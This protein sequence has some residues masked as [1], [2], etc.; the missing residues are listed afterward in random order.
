METGV[1]PVQS[2][3]HRYVALRLTRVTAVF[4]VVTV[5]VTTAVQTDSSVT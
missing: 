4:S 1:S 5:L 2:S 3:V